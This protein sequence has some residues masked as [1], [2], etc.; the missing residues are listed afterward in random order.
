[1][2]LRSSESTELTATRARTPPPASIKAAP[3][4]RPSNPLSPCSH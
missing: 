4:P 1:L 3:E 2:I